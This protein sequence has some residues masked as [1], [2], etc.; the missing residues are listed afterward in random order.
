MQNTGM[1]LERGYKRCMSKEEKTMTSPVCNLRALQQWS[2]K[3]E[4]A[5]RTACTSDL[6]GGG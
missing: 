6:E 2:E 4:K 3:G 5:L 1:I